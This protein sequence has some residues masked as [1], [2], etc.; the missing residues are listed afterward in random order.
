VVITGTGFTGATVVKFGTS[1]ATFTVNSATQITATAPAEAAATVDVTVTTPGGTS[2][3]VTADHY[4]YNLSTTA[5]ITA[6][7]TLAGKAGTDT[8]TVA[9]TPAHVGDLLVLAVKVGSG[10]VTAS[11]VTGGGVSTW[12]RAQG[13]Y[14]GYAGNDLEIWTGVVTS[15]GAAT[16]TVG[17]SSSVTS[18][19]TGL[20][21]QEFSASSGTSTVWSVDTG[22]GITNASSSSVTFPTLTP[23]GTGELYF[24]YAAVANTG[25]AGSSAGVTYAVTT[26]ADVVAYDTDVTAA[27]APTATQSPA[28]TSGGVGVLIVAST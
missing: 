14:T 5:T 4:T 18:I 3:V 26:D 25:V 13:P 16:V 27:L 21:V 19:Y 1:T 9:V 2:A 20:A 23:T 10:T 17:F 11:S 6:V 8:T 24:G 28:G 22:A 7:G 15:T 12:T